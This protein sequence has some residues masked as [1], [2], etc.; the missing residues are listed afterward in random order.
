MEDEATIG[1]QLRHA[2]IVK[3]LDF[4]MDDDRPV[5]VINHI[6]GT[7]LRELRDSVGALP[8]PHDRVSASR[9]PMPSRPCIT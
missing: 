4:F 6:E 8:A 5:I 7:S 1:M 9:S 3:T 2:H